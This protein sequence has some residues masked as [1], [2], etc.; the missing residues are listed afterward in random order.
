MIQEPRLAQTV[1]S[2]SGE[3][4]ECKERE[5]YPL[6]TTFH[7][8]KKRGKINLE[9][10]KPSGRDLFE[11]RISYQLF[12][13]KLMQNIIVE[14]VLS[15]AGNR[16]LLGIFQNFFWSFLLPAAKYNILQYF[17]SYNIW[18]KAL[19]I[20]LKA[21]VKCCC[22]TFHWRTILCCL[23]LLASFWQKD[24]LF[25]AASFEHLEQLG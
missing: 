10:T 5:N 8:S 11:I 15:N 21:S 1:A 7:K 25:W 23:S 3:I 12:S 20:A 14:I 19:Q 24:S 4:G 2:D 6:S 13:S 17:N 22:F 9:S 18:N 16:N